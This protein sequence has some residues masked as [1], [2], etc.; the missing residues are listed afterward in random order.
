MPQSN[1]ITKI[2][3]KKTALVKICRTST[4]LGDPLTPAWLAVRPGP[5]APAWLAVRPG[6]GAPAWLA[7]R[8][9]PGAPAWL[10][11]RPGPDGAG[12]E[13]TRCGRGYSAANTRSVCRSISSRWP[14]VLSV[15]LA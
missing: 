10:A 4:A 12:A 14:G 3:N 13:M 1:E 2:I 9:G 5:G 6:P 7:V 15:T 8:P 11:V